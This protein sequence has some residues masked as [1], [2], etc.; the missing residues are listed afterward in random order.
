MNDDAFWN[1]WQRY[2][3]HLYN[4]SLRHMSGIR[5][6]ADD[7]LS[8]SMLL[9]HARLPAY[10]PRIENLEAWLTRLTSNVCHDMH[11]EHRRDHRRAVSLDDVD[12]DRHSAARAPSPEDEYQLA[13]TQAAL[14][15][16]IAL[17]PPRIRDV[18]RLRVEEMPYDA[19]AQS[20]SITSENARKRMQQGRAVLQNRLAAHR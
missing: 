18:V 11:R 19:I 2:R 8:R 9:A 10:A 16:A 13:E 6:D 7:A 15:T 20:L 12:V 1:V 5:A 3:S 14:G 4:V 17:L